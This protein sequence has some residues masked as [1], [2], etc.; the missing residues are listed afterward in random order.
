MTNTRAKMTV[1]TVEKQGDD[2]ETV[3]FAAVGVSG[4]YP[5]DG[6]DENNTFAKFTPNADLS[7]TIRNPALIGKFEVGKAYYV[8]L[9]PVE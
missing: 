8:D 6:S 5:E 4:N 2:Q 7:L 1:R 3:R 9:T